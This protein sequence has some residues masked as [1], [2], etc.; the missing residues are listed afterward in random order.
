MKGLGI[1]VFCLSFFMVFATGANAET[2]RMVAT[3]K[4]SSFSQVATVEKNSTVP[5]QYRLTGQ[6]YKAIQLST[7]QVGDQIL[8]HDHQGYADFQLEDLADEDGPQ[9]IMI[10]H[11]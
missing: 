4:T 10:V 9:Y 3:L 8:Q 1:T 7:P 5:Q 2:I 6:E 11:Q